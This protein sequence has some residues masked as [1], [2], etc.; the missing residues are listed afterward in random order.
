MP[1]VPQKIKVSRGGPRRKGRQRPWEASQPPQ[2]KAEL[3]KT[4][5]EACPIDRCDECPRDDYGFCRW[6]LSKQFGG[7]PV[8][9]LSKGGE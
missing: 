3:D 7:L 4:I 5:R 2:Q 9:Q 1:A 6:Q 8:G